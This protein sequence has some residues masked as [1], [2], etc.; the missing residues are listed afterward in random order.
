MTHTLHRSGDRESLKNDF[1]WLMYQTKGVNDKD[2]APKARV[3][4]EA[5]QACN[6]INWGDVKSGNV[7]EIS[8]EEIKT[9][10]TDQSRLRGVFVSRADVTEFV[11]KIK[12]ADLGISVVISGLLD[13]VEQI[14]AGAGVKPHTIN[15]SLGVWGNTKALPSE[16]VLAVTTMCGHHM[17]S[18][19]IVE[20]M[21]SDV[22]DQRITAEEAGR[23]LGRLCPCGIFN[24]IRA[25]RE[26]EKMAKKQQ[27]CDKP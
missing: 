14:C 9:K 4:I 19:G 22:I 25:A 13:E 6:C 5:A 11:K 17:V 18:S 10:L 1:V 26:I 24:H 8:A 7:L 12:A 2:I 27:P 15:Y 20:K 3:F 23:E 16:D 21:V